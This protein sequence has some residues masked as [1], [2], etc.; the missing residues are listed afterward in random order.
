M[1]IRAVFF[2]FDYTLADTGD[3][4]VHGFVDACPLLGLPAP[5][6]QAVRR[7]VGG[8]LEEIYIASVGP[9]PDRDTFA[10]FREAY[11]DSID[12]VSCEMTRF[13]PETRAA[14]SKMKDM[15]LT[16]CIVTNKQARF[17]REPLEKAGLLKYFD[18]IVGRDEMP[19][20]KPDPRGILRLAGEISLS[21]RQIVFCGDSLFDARAAQNAD[22]SFAAVLTGQ[23]TREE[24]LPY[25]PFAICDNLE[26]L[27]ETLE[28]AAL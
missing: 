4:V 23:T 18:R 3:I 16:L 6:A 24:F 10:R 8:T 12:P 5:D 9:L 14:L 7:T 2:D 19:A 22:L 26:K 28:N 27:A 25:R 13:F 17:A 20:P 15:G 21:P 11:H 1:N